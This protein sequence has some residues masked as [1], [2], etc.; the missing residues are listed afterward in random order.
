MEMVAV[1]SKT[2]RLW[3]ERN[4]IPKN[5]TAQ[6]R[7]AWYVAHAAHCSCRPIPEGVAQLIAA[8]KG[9]AP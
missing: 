2:N 1:M 6:Q 7:I 9:T 3:H 4:R 8:D 5:P